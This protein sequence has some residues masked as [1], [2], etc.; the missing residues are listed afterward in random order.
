MPA[1]DNLVPMAPPLVYNFSPGGM[2]HGH[3]CPSQTPNA[4]AGLDEK[5]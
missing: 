5:Q 2:L 4:C 1:Q 3:G